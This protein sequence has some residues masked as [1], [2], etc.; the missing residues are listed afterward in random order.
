MWLPAVTTT[1]PAAEPVLLAAAKQYLRI[2]AAD[3]SFD[4]EIGMY[5]AASRAEVE[6]ITNTRLITQV[7]DL[8]CESFYDFD[9]LPIGPV[10]SID[11]VNY[12]DASGDEHLLADTEYRL[13]AG[14]IDAQ[15]VPGAGWLNWPM[16]S[17]AADA[18][19][20]TATVGYGAAGTAL[21]RDLYFVVLHAIRAKFDGRELAIEHMLVNHR[22]WMS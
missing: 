19:R 8:R 15:I 7:V 18:V 10:Q 4:D 22:I 13:I 11:A 17:E 3:A 14:T 1:P 21:P 16:L 12:L 20:V 5:I 2:D 9:H 6:S